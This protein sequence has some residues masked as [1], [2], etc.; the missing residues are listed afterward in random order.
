MA[1]PMR[2]NSSNPDMATVAPAG[3]ITRSLSALRHSE[4]DVESRSIGGTDVE[5]HARA[6][7]SRTRSSEER[8]PGDLTIPPL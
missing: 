2:Y 1:K 8:L 5:F 6:P 4:G 7:A 3:E